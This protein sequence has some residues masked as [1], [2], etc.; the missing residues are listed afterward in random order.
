[1][2][3]TAVANTLQ[4][5]GCPNAPESLSTNAYLSPSLISASP[6]RLQ[7]VT[8]LRWLNAFVDTESL[9]LLPLVADILSATLPC[10][11][12]DRTDCSALEI[13]IRIN[14]KLMK[15]VL[16]A[17]EAGPHSSASNSPTPSAD[18]SDPKPTGELDVSAVLRVT[19]VMFEHAS[20][21]TRLSALRWVEVLVDVFPNS[22]FDDSAQLLPLL[23]RFLSDPA[24]EACCSPYFFETSLHNWRV[25]ADPSS[26]PYY[27]K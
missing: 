21:L 7:Q 23:L 6:E 17:E 12:D 25:N 20:V 18:T 19:Y 10:L 15:A 13:A 5:N 2:K 14:E 16:C 11:I 4:R 24:P 3:R 1:M 27:F 26:I 22:V 9:S 8:A